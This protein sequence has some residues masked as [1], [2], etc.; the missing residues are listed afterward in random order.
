MRDSLNKLLDN[1]LIAL[2]IPE[3]PNHP[4]QKYRITKKGLQLLKGK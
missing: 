1:K 2:T 3:T 4:N